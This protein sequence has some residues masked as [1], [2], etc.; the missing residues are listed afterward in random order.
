MIAEKA[1]RAPEGRPEPKGRLKP[2][3]TITP[4]TIT[5]ATITPA[6]TGAL[7]AV[8]GGKPPA[9]VTPAHW[10]KSLRN[11]NINYRAGWWAVTVQV[12]KNKSLLGAIVGK[13]VVL[14]A[15]GRAV[16]AY[17]RARRRSIPGSSSSTLW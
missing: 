8:A 16:E 13:R 7:G 6:G 9:T 10:H 4:A 1:A 3:A 11:P 17:W 15:L 2:P 14:N 5:P 12:A